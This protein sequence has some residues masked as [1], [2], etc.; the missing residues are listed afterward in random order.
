MLL[1][2]SLPDQSI[3]G[4][5]KFWIKETNRYSEGRLRFFHDGL[6]DEFVVGI[7]KF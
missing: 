4:I 1:H 5:E 7:E 6:P 2:Y 3:V